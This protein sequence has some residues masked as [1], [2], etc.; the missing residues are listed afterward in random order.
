MKK[1][2]RFPRCGEKDGH[3]LFMKKELK[4]LLLKEKDD[5]NLKAFRNKQ[6]YEVILIDDSNVSIDIDTVED[7]Q[8]FLKGKEQ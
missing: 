3:P 7:Y 5:S 4:E 6:D 1:L 2:V 8:N